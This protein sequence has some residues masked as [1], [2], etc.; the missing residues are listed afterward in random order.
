MKT[1]REYGIRELKDHLSKVIHAVRDGETVVVTD[2]NRPVARIVPIRQ[3]AKDPDAWLQAWV[4]EGGVTWGGGKPAGLPES[5]RPRGV[6][7]SGAV[8]EDRR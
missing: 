8:L 5:E 1:A 6:D 2:R 3:Q 7:L 4:A